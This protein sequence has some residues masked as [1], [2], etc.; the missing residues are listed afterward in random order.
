MLQTKT[1]RIVR[2]ADTLFEIRTN[3]GVFLAKSVAVAAGPYSLLFAHDLGYAGD[4]TI[5]P[6]A[7]NFYRTRAVSLKGKV[8][9]VQDPDLPFAAPHMDSSI[10]DPD[11]IRIGPTVN[12]LPL[13]ER[14]HLL[15]FIDFLKV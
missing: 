4:Y 1:R 8:Y 6:V 7:G 12:P 13:L 5:L 2:R 15:T 9:T 10:N 14:H 3:N 11:E